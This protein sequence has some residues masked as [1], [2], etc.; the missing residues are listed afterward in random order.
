[1]MPEERQMTPRAKPG[2]PL[3]ARRSQLLARTAICG[4]LAGISATAAHALPVAGF[5]EVNPGGGLPVIMDSVARTDITLNAPRTVISWSSY[6]VKPDEI[7]TYNFASRNGIV[8]NRI[9]SLQPSRIEGVI[10]G[11]VGGVSGGNIWFVSQNSIIIGKG[12]QIDAGGLLFG[13]GTANTATF[14]D[15]ANNTFAFDGNDAFP[16]SRLWVLANAR[17]RANGGMVAFTGPTVV[18]R[19]NATI[20]ATEGSV[21]YGSAKSYSIRLAPGAGGDFDLV[22][23]IVPNAAGG[24][25]GGLALDLAGETRANAVFIAAVSKTAVGSAVINLEGLITAQAARAD[26]GDIVL[27]GG[28]GIAGRAPG[29]SIT[30]VAE[31]TFYLNRASASRDLLL[32]NVGQTFAR[33]WARPSGELV[34]PLSLQE[35]ANQQAICDADPDCRGGNSSP[36]AGNGGGGGPPSGGGGNGGGPP[37]GGGGNG[38]CPPASPQCIIVDNDVVT[39]LFDPTAVSSITV[40]RDT[41]IKATATIELGRIV[42]SRD[43]SIEGAD[44]VANSLIATGNLAVTSTTGGVKLAGVSVGRDGMISGKTDVGIDSISAPQKLTVTSG[45]GIVVGDGMSSVAGAITLTAA[46]GVSVDLA[47]ANIDAINARSLVTLKGGALDVGTITAPRIFAQAASLKIGTATAIGD[48]YAI[49]TGGDAIV[50]TANAGDDVYVLA[51]NGTASLTTGNLTGA[52]PDVVGVAFPGSPDAD[53]N[54]RVVVVQSTNL[55]ARLGLGSGGVTGATAVTVTAGRDAIVDV[56]RDTPATLRVAAVRDATLKAPTVRL[57]AVTAGRDLA[58]GS[59]VGDFNLLTNLVANRSISVSAAGVLRVADVRADAGSITLT[60]TSIQAGNV[61]ASEDLTLKALTGGVSTISYKVGRDLT[62]QGSTLSL[63]SSIGP[64]AR[65]LSIT[66]LGNFTST[67]P[68]SAGRN[69]TLDVAGKASVAATSASGNLRIVAGDLDLTG[70]LVAPTAQIESRNGALRVGGAAG[71]TPGTLTL[72]STDFGRLRVS[73]TLRIFAGSV[74]GAARGDLTLQ[75]LSINP[76]STPNVAF[77]AGSNNTARVTGAVTPTA[78]GGIV[79]IGDATD[80]TWR[81]DSILV[82]G[83]LGAATFSGGNYTGISAFDEVRLAARQ[84]ILFGSQRFIALIQGTAIGDIDIANAKPS[85]VAPT[86]DETSRVFVSA[87]R[88]EVSAD[89]K[90]VQQNT[91]P[92][93]SSQAVGIFVTGRF[94]PALIIDPPRLVELWGAIGGQDGKVTSGTAAG[95]ALTFAILDNNGAP[96]ARPDGASYRFNSCDVGT[97]LCPG[98]GGGQGGVLGAPDVLNNAFLG[99]GKPRPPP[100]DSTSEEEGTAAIASAEALTTPAVVLSVAPVDPDEIVADPVVTGT[101]S[102]EIWRQ[103]RQKK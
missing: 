94:N 4:V 20:T 99:G 72:D 15:P 96:V 103:R 31:T 64:V 90:V 19:A 7:V 6:N 25:E 1:M 16:G 61:S 66:S 69:L 24:S 70:S 75:S 68:L 101:G 17:V 48:I 9:I 50:G 91:S 22:D 86:T 13:I 47:S 42:T 100:R 3:P 88:L 98:F 102:E 27:S 30:G 14:L 51:T 85:G 95:R 92:T 77:L 79:R 65:D 40:A 43:L 11:T 67:T 29:P 81:P 38:G 56:L 60:G 49:A 82:T 63:G 33:P 12:A 35:E 97:A 36:P 54:G 23:F 83:S 46:Q 80:L 8:L 41:R 21:L 53:G 89:N 58:I 5:A 93:G 71:D 37:S 39:S 44:V 2:H 87:G 26:G 55:D 28:G 45:G 18:T 74:S 10:R 84:D 59:T 62:V 32:N 57:D 73:G 52:G 76:G 34:D 78:S